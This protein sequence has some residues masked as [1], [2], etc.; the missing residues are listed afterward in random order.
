[1]PG[2]PEPSDLNLALGIDVSERRGLDLALLSSE[3][4]LHGLWSRVAVENLPAFLARWRPAAIGIDAP[5]QWR[6]GA[7]CR[8]GERALFRR[9]IRLF[10]T[11]TADRATHPFYRWMAVGIL[12]W[13]VVAQGG[14]R[15]YRGEGSV[16][17]CALEVFPHATATI[18]AKR[19]VEKRAR[20]M[21]LRAE[22]VELPQHIHQDGVDAALAA[23]TVW[24]ALLGAHEALGDEQSGWIVVPS[25]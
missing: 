22:G 11:P 12:V 14:Y 6:S 19:P 2:W 16:W 7:S 24:Y 15:R 10:F 9:G 13:Q 3:K 4:T 8:A 5:S 20:A 17:G 18:L 23:L 21:V 1:M 25:P